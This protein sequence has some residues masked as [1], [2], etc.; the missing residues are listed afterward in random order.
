[1]LACQ[2]AF[3]RLVL[4]L[5]AANL[6]AQIVIAAKVIV[7]MPPDEVLTVI[8]TRF[9]AAIEGHDFYVLRGKV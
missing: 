3:Q 4:R 8:E 1:M 7:R 6:P 2:N 5:A 9:A